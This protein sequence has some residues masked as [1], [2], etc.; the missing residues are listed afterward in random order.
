MSLAG[1]GASVSLTE[2]GLA[3]KPSP[4]WDADTTQGEIHRW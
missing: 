3:L 4:V 2:P 1:A